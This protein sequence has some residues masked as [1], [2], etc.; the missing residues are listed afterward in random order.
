MKRSILIFFLSVTVIFCTVANIGIES[1]EFRESKVFTCNRERHKKVALTFDD[2]PH[3]VLTEKITKILKIR[4]ESNLFV[5]GINA[6]N[7]P[8]YLN[9]IIEADVR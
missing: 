7:Y 2:S 6:V 4:R 1:K 3:P 8:S 5:V 9:H